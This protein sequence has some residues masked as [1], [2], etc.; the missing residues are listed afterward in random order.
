VDEW[1]KLYKPATPPAAERDVVHRLSLNGK[2][3]PYE[4]TDGF[5]TVNV[6][7]GE[8]I[9]RFA[10][11][12][13]SLAF[14]PHLTFSNLDGLLTRVGA[15]PIG[16]E[17]ER[18]IVETWFK[19]NNVEIFMKACE[20]IAWG[21]RDG[22]YYVRVRPRVRDRRVLVDDLLY[23]YLW[24]FRS[25]IPQVIKRDDII[26]V[27]R[28][29]GP[30]Q[31]WNIGFRASATTHCLKRI[32]MTPIVLGGALNQIGFL[33][34]AGGTAFVRLTGAALPTIAPYSEDYFTSGE[35]RT[36]LKELRDY[37]TYDPVL[38]MTIFIMGYDHRIHC[39]WVR[40]RPK[41]TRRLR[42]VVGVEW[43][44]Y[45]DLAPVFRGANETVKSCMC[46]MARLLTAYFDVY[47]DQKL[48]KLVVQYRMA[49]PDQGK[50]FR[51]LARQ[52]RFAMPKDELVAI[53]EGRSR[54]RRDDSEF[55]WMVVNVVYDARI[56]C[57][58]VEPDTARY[59]VTYRP[60]PDGST[61]RIK[62]CDPHLAMRIC[63]E[64]VR[65]MV[66]CWQCGYGD[67]FELHARHDRMMRPPAEP[68]SRSIV[69]SKEKDQNDD[70]YIK[71]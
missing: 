59:A 26:K 33:F 57:A 11:V 31:Y 64:W 40:R 61:P 27:K 32:R 30:Y 66:W 70:E 46:R 19:P 51:L 37:R 22:D 45:D 10:D 69:N 2:L 4:P 7:G 47:R 41:P 23:C 48:K 18:W 62:R 5:L 65:D 71:M 36:M 63:A 60:F 12:S 14:L 1:G 49:V 35:L 56:G 3:E 53:L 6:L 68:R 38:F 13:K 44:D 52:V 43:P 16:P 34:D 8:S 39:A 20:C 55:L 58:S 25:K 17:H 9:M 67:R 24:H 28:V 50:L 21:T 29:D 42:G 15:S 54:R